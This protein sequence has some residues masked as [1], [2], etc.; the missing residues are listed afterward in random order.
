MNLNDAQH[1][2]PAT[3][4]RTDAAWL[5]PLETALGDVLSAYPAAPATAL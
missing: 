5:E 4:T 2:Q 3:K 1:L